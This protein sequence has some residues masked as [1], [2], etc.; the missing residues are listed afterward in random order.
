[1]S[2]KITVVSLG[3]GDPE[4]LNMKTVRALKS[5]CSVILRTERHPAAEWLL[6]QNIPFA[7]MDDLYAACEDFDELNR[8]ICSRLIQLSRDT[9][10]VYAVQDACTDRTVRMLTESGAGRPQIEIIPGTSTYDLCV[11]SSVPVSAQ[12]GIA[13]I[14][15]SDLTDSS[16]IDPNLSLLVTEIDNQILAGQVKICLSRMF[17]DDQTVYLIHGDSSPVPIPL[18]MLDR[19]KGTDHFT[20]VFIAGTD[21]LRRNR[22]TLHDLVCL[23]DHLRSPSGCPW[24]RG[25]THETLRPYMIEEAWEC[26]A[27]IDQ[28]DYDHLCEELGDLLFQI[29][30]HSSIGRSYD[31]FSIDDVINAICSKMIRR[32]PHV[33][34]EGVPFHPDHFP[35]EWEKMK[36]A[37]T[38]NQSVIESLEDVSEA[39]PSLKY[40]SKVLKKLNQIYSFHPCVHDLL[41]ELEHSADVFLSSSK[42]LS[43]SDLSGLLLLCSEICHV[44]NL[45]SELL[46]HQ[47]V[48]RIKKS[49]K[50]IQSSRLHDGKSLEHLTF[51]ELCVYLK[52]V[53]GEI[54]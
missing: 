8:K 25:Q 52:H 16:F 54:E 7:S 41:E 51:R 45:D 3:T 13:V 6:Q 22:Y 5:S 26:I 32:H 34:R 2:S 21:Y 44:L 29:V 33:F 15:A 20:S 38:G 28:K 43:V 27:S 30:F 36:Q 24:D 49:L 53:E 42:P 11:S 23:M 40:A 39:L 4:L 9:D 12:C 50:D 47:V 10:L 19:Q 35:V 37:E 14:P 18:Y 46:L 48:D 1:M 17:D 31:E